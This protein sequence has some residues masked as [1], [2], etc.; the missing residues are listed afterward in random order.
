MSNG[1][2]LL[3]AARVLRTNW[4]LERAS[5]GAPP[6]LSAAHVLW[7]NWRLERASKGAQPALSA[8][9]VLWTNW[10]LERASK[11]A[12]PVL[13][14]VTSRSLKASA[15]CNINIVFAYLDTSFQLYIS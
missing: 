14:L 2:P 13:Y 12:Q 4:R 6:A 9:H 5:K 15:A 8:A 10:R 1:H 7:T 11:G 3:S